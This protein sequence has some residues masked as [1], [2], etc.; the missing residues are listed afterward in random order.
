MYVRYMYVEYVY[1]HVLFIL[2]GAPHAVQISYI[3]VQDDLISK[4]NHIISSPQDIVP[5][6]REG[7]RERERERGRK[8]EREGVQ[9]R[10]GCTCAHLRFMQYMYPV[11]DERLGSILHVRILSFRCQ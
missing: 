3:Y 1:I 7:G 11:H 2:I 10:D 6:E 8:G 5:G 4:T 9:G